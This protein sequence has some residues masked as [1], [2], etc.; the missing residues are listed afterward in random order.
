MVKDSRVKTNSLKSYSKS[1][2]DFDFHKILVQ[3][4][5]GKKLDAGD[6]DWR[7]ALRSQSGTLLGFEQRDRDIDRAQVFCSF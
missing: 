5:P 4:A 1:V 6:C 7:G 2:F 3:S